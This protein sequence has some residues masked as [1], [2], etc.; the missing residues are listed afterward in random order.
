VLQSVRLNT[1]LSILDN[2]EEGIK[3]SN[4]LTHDFQWRDHG[5]LPLATWTSC[6]G[7]S[8]KQEAY[9]PQAQAASLTRLKLQVI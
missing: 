5:T 9:K 1:G 8:Y 6:E 3:M 7:P 2:D 4:D